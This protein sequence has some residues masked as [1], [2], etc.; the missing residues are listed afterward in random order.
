M[1]KGFFTTTFQ[2]IGADGIERKAVVYGR[3]AHDIVVI[4]GLKFARVAG[5][6]LS[7]F[8]F[9]WQPLHYDIAAHFN[10]N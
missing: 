3:G 5:G 2:H 1:D 9:D 6:A 7:N 10:L 8:I 4:E